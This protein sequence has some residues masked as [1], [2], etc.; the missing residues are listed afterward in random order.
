M[1]GNDGQLIFDTSIDRSGFE[2]D[3]SSLES[4]AKQG[5]SAMAD[6]SKSKMGEF[7]KMEDIY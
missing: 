6:S 1:G 5:I 3:M 4:T 7:W 2:K